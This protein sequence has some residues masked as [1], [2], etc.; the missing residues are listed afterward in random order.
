VLAPARS[1]PL[2][3]LVATSVHAWRTP[4]PE[5]RSRA[6]RFAARLLVW[7]TAPLATLE[8]RERL[9]RL[10]EP[11][12]FAFN[13][14][15]SLES[16]LVPALLIFHRRGRIV[17]FLVD[18]MYLHLPL[19]GWCIRQIEPIPV[20]GKPDRFRL[21]ERYR[22]RQRRD[23][24]PVQAAVACLES[25]ASLGI[26]PEGTRNRSASQLRRARGGLARIVMATSVPVV[27]VGIYYPAKDRLGRIPRLGRFV[28][29]IGEPLDFTH[30]RE[31]GD[32]QAITDRVMA[33]L[34]ALCE[35]SVPPSRAS[36][37]KP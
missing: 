35:K 32:V 31:Q 9:A 6:A 26:F 23:S 36:R 18:W 5:L 12:L 7:L 28:V 4:L 13:H 24:D 11:V 25:G 17:R 15:N 21:F 19:I 1:R 34:A 14:N 8:S 27:P 10:P 22:Q 37:R 2:P 16:I 3:A 30:E 29:R 20:Y 33:Q